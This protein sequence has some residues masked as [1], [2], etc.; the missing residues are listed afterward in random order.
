MFRFWRREWNVQRSEKTLTNHSV[1]WP[2]AYP[3]CQISTFQECKCGVKIMIYF[4]VEKFYQSI[5][6]RPKKI[7][8]NEEGCGT[9]SVPT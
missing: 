7:Q 1:Q 4:Y 5:H 9:E 6:T 8:M 3:G 2:R